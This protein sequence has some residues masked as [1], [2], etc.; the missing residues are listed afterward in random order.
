MDLVFDCHLARPL[1]VSVENFWKI[2]DRRCG[3]A[4]AFAF[5]F[6][7]DGSKF[8]YIRESAR[9]LAGLPAFASTPEYP[10]AY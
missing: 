9:V 8:L 3:D 6:L 7:D 1:I 10:E 5:C 4:S 2:L